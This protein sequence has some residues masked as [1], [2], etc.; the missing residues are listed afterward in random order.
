MITPGY[1]Q[2]GSPRHPAHTTAAPAL[3]VLPVHWNEKVNKYATAEEHWSYWPT[4]NG[5]EPA[6]VPTSPLGPPHTPDVGPTCFSRGAAWGATRMSSG[7]EGLSTGFLHPSGYKGENRDWSG[8][9]WVFSLPWS[10]PFCTSPTAAPLT[11]LPYKTEKSCFH[12]TRCCEN[13]TH[14]ESGR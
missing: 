14:P 7:T 10:L 8:A 13:E 1:R 11:R 3:P 9:R 2:P 4:E 6:R 5:N 12:F